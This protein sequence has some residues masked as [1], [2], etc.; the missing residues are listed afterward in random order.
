MRNRWPVVVV[1]ASLCLNVAL[2][3]TYVFRRARSV[4]PRRFNARGFT[5]EVRER[6][7]HAREASM[8]EFSALVDSV[9]STD[10]ILWAEMRRESPDSARVESL[11]RELGQL[12]GRM[13]AGV[14]R[15]MHREL[16]LMPEEARAQYL[17]HMMKMKPGFDGPRGRKGRRSG[18]HAGP[19][20]CE[21]TP[22]VPPE[23]GQ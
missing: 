6:L 8:P 13:R 7:R 4:R 9:E 3:G 2:V 17:K 11:C 12:H 18:R 22:C 20:R 23:S 15:Q 21:P 5:S 14:F 1:V 16:Q 19:H 10:S